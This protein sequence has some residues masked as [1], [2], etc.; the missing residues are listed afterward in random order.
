M[1]YQLFQNKFTNT[2][3]HISFPL[4]DN[5]R[6]ILLLPHNFR[7]NTYKI[8]FKRSFQ[9]YIRRGLSLIFKQTTKI[10][11]LIEQNKEWYV[12]NSVIIT[13]KNNQGKESLIPSYYTFVTYSNTPRGA[14]QLQESVNY[15]LLMLFY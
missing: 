13:A 2:Q 4:L 15:S 8:R 7:A 9:G 5:K 1:F 11:L 3:N 12:H 10:T 14:T 6:Y